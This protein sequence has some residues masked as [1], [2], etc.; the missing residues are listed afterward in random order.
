M[1]KLIVLLTLILLI[2]N[3]PPCY[4][5]A[6]PSQEGGYT[7]V[8]TG[9]YDPDAVRLIVQ[10]AADANPQDLNVLATATGGEL[11]RTGPLNYA[12]FQYRGLNEAN[13]EGIVRKVLQSPIVIC[14]EWSKTY[15]MD[16]MA[17]TAAISDPEYS[18]QWSLRKVRAD[19]AWDE[20]A[21][22]EGIVIA[23]IDTGVDLNSTELQD[24]SV[25]NLV[26]GYNAYTGSTST[27]AIQD[28]HGH[29][30]SVAGLIAALNN[31]RGIIGVAYKAKIMPVKVMDETGQGEDD[32]IADGIVWAADHGA[33]IINMSIG[34]DSENDILDDALDYAAAKG[35]LL[36]ASSGN[37]QEGMPQSIA[38]QAAVRSSLVSYPAAHPEV[39]A[40]SAVDINDQITDFSL[41][42]PE[43]AMS[44]P[45]DKILTTYWTTKES[46]YAYV[47]GTSIA[48]PF[49]SGAA[50]LIWSKYPQLT[51]QEVKKALFSS[52]YDLGAEGRDDSYGYGRL[53]CY[54]A[55]KTLSSPQT[56]T[57]P[58]SL[59]WDGGIVSAG[60]TG[61][62]TGATLTV[63]AGAFA[64]GVD[65]MHRDRKISLSLAKTDTPGEF[66]TGITGGETFAINWGEAQP[67]KV[68]DLSID[69]VLPNSIG[70]GAESGYMAY[71][72]RWSGSRW[73]RIGGG[74]TG[75][76]TTVKAAIYEPG[77]YRVGWSAI[78]AG[79]RI[80]G[81]D[82]ITTALQIAR[83]A[84]PTGADTV[85]IARA[86]AFPDALAGAPL[87][88][89]Y[90]APIL[91]TNRD[92]LP[93]NVYKAIADFGA[94]KVYILGGTGA[95]SAAVE[96]KLET[97][98]SVTR[99]EGSDRYGT[100]AAVAD[101]LGTK[102]SAVVVN[103]A[104]FPDAIS[105][106]ANAAIEGKPI[107][108]TN[109]ASLNS[110][111]ENRLRIDAVTATE[112]IG[113]TAAV[114]S[115]VLAALPGAVRI[116]GSN[117]YATSAAVLR[118]NEPE[119]NN[120]YIA[121]GMNYPDALTGGILAAGGNTTILLVAPNGLTTEQR[122]LLLNYK[123]RKVIAIGGTKALPPSVLSEVKALGLI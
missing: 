31:S 70:A 36:I 17:V 114:S 68:L 46:G 113:G 11:I 89:K 20:G 119:G 80:A 75:N 117:R 37:N 69:A 102:G 79:D 59:G 111:T 64:L 40:V 4:A 76:G 108:L 28:D 98:T 66:P 29:G 52:A 3:V 32:I 19:Q 25:S 13:R 62:E 123:G 48:T 84:F 65:S 60:S 35:C 57:S 121:T 61:E 85:I 77:T 78:S 12:T 30:T 103:G 94:S 95:V 101:L 7:S 21:T 83:T 118:D 55:L 71:I 16:E 82:R 43:M 120:L 115:S 1:K 56:V 41:V 122:T 81:T 53:D 112:V 54:R 106:A 110:Q 22:G 72:Y 100:A 92:N 34:A 74:F 27:Q 107:L 87:A 9:E 73:I 105:T 97:L 15:T 90:H 47:T 23:V 33:D 26:G 8:L 24:G 58:A 99:I 51:A 45:G 88:Y 104:N 42:G 10:V 91:L 50:A 5:L 109:A 18:D 116:S 67:Q 2:G 93:D 38:Q 96:A 39:L 63:S 44:A 14:A 49:V 86:D 6:A